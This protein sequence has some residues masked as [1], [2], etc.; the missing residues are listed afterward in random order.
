MFEGVKKVI[1]A[2]RRTELLQDIFDKPIGTVA[3]AEIDGEKVFGVNRRSPNNDSI[4]DRERDKLINRFAE[5]NPDKAASIAKRKR[6]YE[7]ILSCGDLA[8]AEGSSQ[9]W[10]HA[11]WARV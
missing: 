10:W 8:A 1:D 11:G 9:A 6:P 5:L 4:D 3:Y 2:Y 7:C